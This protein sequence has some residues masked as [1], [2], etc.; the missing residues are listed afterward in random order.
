MMVTSD[1]RELTPPRETSP[2]L[3][4][5]PEAWY[6]TFVNRWHAGDS[7][8]WLSH[9]YDPIGWHGA[10]MAVMARIFWPE[11]ATPALIWACVAHDLG[12]LRG[13]D[14]PYCAKGDPTLCGAHE[15]VEERALVEMGAAYHLSAQDRL[16]LKFLDRLDAYLWVQTR[17]PE[18]LGRPDWI[19]G[20]REIEDK[21]AVLGVTL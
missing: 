18:L 9:L 2:A 7:A 16:R 11:D 20:R 12:E 5:A 13:G 10:R 19:A 15:R 8:P 1:M 6:A 14:A 21:A 3:I 4:R 17:A